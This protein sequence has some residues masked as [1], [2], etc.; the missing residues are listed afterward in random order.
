MS[1]VLF[2]HLTA[3]TVDLTVRSLILRALERS[4]RVVVR[5][6]RADRLEALDRSLWLGP[7]DEFI[8][9]GLAGG[10]HDAD[11]PV[12]LTTDP[13]PAEGADVLMLLD[14]AVLAEG[15]A[16][17]LNRVFV[18]FDGLDAVGLDQARD[19]WRFVS[20]EGIAAQYWSDKSGRWEMMR[21]VP[22][23]AARQV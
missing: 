11:Q 10:P 7:Q 5:G 17:G 22:A 18:V 13:H 9:H 6:A 2:Y 14:G 12:L 16:K 23:G 1:S 8:P 21:E 4:W 15:E 3:S 19:L 20:R